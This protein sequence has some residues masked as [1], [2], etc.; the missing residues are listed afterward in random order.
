MSEHSAYTAN[1][2][3]GI[4][5]HVYKPRLEDAIASHK[6]RIE[7]T[8][9]SIGRNPSITG[10]EME[11]DQNELEEKPPQLESIE[12]HLRTYDQAH[13]LFINKAQLIPPL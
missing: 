12:P 5:S 13:P 6:Q 10:P 1:S 9:R 11:R 7:G 8:I 2:I 3:E 4:L